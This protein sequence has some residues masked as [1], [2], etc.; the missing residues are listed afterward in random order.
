MGAFTHKEKGFRGCISFKM[1]GGCR[2]SFLLDR[3]SRDMLKI[4]F[5]NIYIISCQKVDDGPIV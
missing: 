5:P 3:W 2:V 4:T 1:A